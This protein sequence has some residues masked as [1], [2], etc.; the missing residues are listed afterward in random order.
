MIRNVIII[1]C[2]F[3]LSIEEFAKY[4]NQWKRNKACANWFWAKMIVK[5]KSWQ[6]R[7]KMIVKCRS[8]RCD[9]AV[10]AKTRQNQVLVQLI[11]DEM[12]KFM[13]INGFGY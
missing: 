11:S 10:S 7:D 9:T 3:F 13:N 1:V 4:E 12:A 8:W 2:V 5:C 6:P